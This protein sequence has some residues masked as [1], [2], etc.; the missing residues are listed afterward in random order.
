MH[1]H[2]PMPPSP[3]PP[4]RHWYTDVE[5]AYEKPAEC[6]CHFPPMPDNCICV[7][8]EDVYR[9]NSTYSA[10]SALI[11][12]G[13][14]VSA[15][16]SAAQVA[17]SAYLWNQ[18]YTAVSSYSGLWN[19]V[20]AVSAKTDILAD[21]LVD[22]SGKFTNHIGGTLE[23]A[24]HVD[25]ETIIGNGTPA[26]P[27]RLANSAFSAYEH[28]YDTLQ[29]Q[30]DALEDNVSNCEENVT[31]Q[32]ASLSGGHVQNFELIMQIIGRVPNSGNV[33]MVWAHDKDMRQ[34]QAN[35][36]K[37]DS[38]QNWIYFNFYPGDYK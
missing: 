34:E 7:T 26:D 9:W 32:L 16:T 19:S 38:T 28:E 11:D 17:V 6:E 4:Y 30:I 15:I 31:Q 27:W 5:P 36:Y 2:P 35:T 24:H 10:F 37:N 22:L 13:I 8:E 20:S 29:K 3:F 21:D 33:P 25:N 18:T 12:S 23:F 14:D 1:P